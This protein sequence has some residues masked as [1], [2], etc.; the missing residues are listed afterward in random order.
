MSFH[1]KRGPRDWL[2]SNVILTEAENEIYKA[3]APSREFDVPYVAGY[4]KDG[5]T[6]YIDRELPR[7][8]EHDGDFFVVDTPL[9]MHEVVEKSI[10]EEEAGIPYQLAHQIALRAERACVEAAGIPWVTYNRWFM[11]W[12]DRIGGRTRYDD[13]PPDLDLEPYRDEDDR[14]TLTRMFA[15]GKPL[16]N[17]VMRPRTTGR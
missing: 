7:G 2:V 15:D 5:K 12:I 14:K 17:G 6:F 16:W 4:S 13:C 10:M 9:M 11:Q 1:F 8:F 3:I